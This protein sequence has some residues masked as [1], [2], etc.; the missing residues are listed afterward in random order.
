ME[1]VKRHSFLIIA[2]LLII[3]MYAFFRSDQAVAPN[4]ISK[5]LSPDTELSD[6][7]L[8]TYVESDFNKEEMMFKEVVI[9]KHNNT[10][11]LVTFPCSDVCPEATKRIIQ[12]DVES[13]LCESV[14]GELKSI[15]VPVAIT[16]MPQEFCFPK[17][18]VESGE[19]EFTEKRT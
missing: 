7:D 5:V 4:G 15:L 1:I 18:I 9:G 17:A 10:P 2:I 12:Y 8:I 16:V 14:G 11:V 13:N 19:Y 3:G 6:A